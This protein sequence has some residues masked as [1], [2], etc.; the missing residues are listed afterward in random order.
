MSTT[1]TNFSTRASV[2]EWIRQVG[3]MYN[4][5][6]AAISDEQFKS[7]FAGK[8]RTAQDFTSEIVG[9]NFMVAR[10]IS[11][12]LVSMPSDEEQK[13]FR[14]SFTS[15]SFAQEKITESTN[16]LAAALEALSDEQL[17]EEVNAP[18]GMPITKF[19]FANLQAGHIWYHDG[20]LNYIQALN[21][22]EAIH[23]M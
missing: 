4:K 3:Q 8:A 17:G 10:I 1:A 9:M 23:W 14:D 21:G 22:D 11:G 6:L 16:A 12:E 13:A 5:D 7:S 19:G 2:A 20:Q 15:T 18:W